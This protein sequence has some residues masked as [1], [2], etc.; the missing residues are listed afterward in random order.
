MF[1]DA[2]ALVVGYYS[3]LIAERVGTR[4]P[5]NTQTWPTTGRP[6]LFVRAW[7]T[8]GAAV[9][10]ALDAPII[11]TQVWGTE[12]GDADD[13]SDL[14]SRLRDFMY[15]ANGKLGPVRR[16]EEVSGLYWDPDPDSGAPRY[17]FSSRLYVRARF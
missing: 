9:S 3:G 14:A 2:E 5:N 15:G 7:R 17:T 1:Q 11:T 4:V 13:A 16:V 10:R 6:R 12:A 8:G